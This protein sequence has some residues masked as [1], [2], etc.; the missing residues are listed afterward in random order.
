MPI[1]V[2]PRKTFADFEATVLK[3]DALVSLMIN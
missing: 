2:P 3:G 1:V